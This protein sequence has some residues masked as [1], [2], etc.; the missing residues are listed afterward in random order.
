M[1]AAVQRTCSG[2]R[3][4]WLI[5]SVRR[6][7]KP[8]H[9]GLAR[10]DELLIGQAVPARTMTNQT[11][12][13]R[14]TMGAIAALLVATSTPLAAQN[15]GMPE[16]LPV[17]PAPAAPAP[18]SGAPAVP[19]AASPAIESPASKPASTPRTTALPNR[20]PVNEAP[21]ITTPIAPAPVE[22]AP[23]DAAPAAIVAAD[24]TETPE[25][26][27]RAR[28]SQSEGSAASAQP[29]AQ[30]AAVR[31]SSAGDAPDDNVAPAAE[32][33]AETLSAL[34]LENT[35]P[36]GVRPAVSEES[37][38]ASEDNSQ[39]DELLLAGLAG[40]AGLGLAGGGLILSRRRKRGSGRPEIQPV[41]GPNMP[42]GAAAPAGNRAPITMPA[43][44]A[45]PEPRRDA[46]ERLKGEQLAGAALIERIDYTQKPGYYTA[47]VD[48][49]PT[50]INPFLTRKYRMRRAHFLDRQL[51]K[52]GESRTFGSF[53]PE[54]RETDRAFE[55]A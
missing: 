36:L 50:A 22:D 12:P 2:N 26:P 20:A 30:T 27:A 10:P 37:V 54:A 28:P 42:N 21:I 25:A 4:F 51:A 24:D 15:S 33:E 46:I 17:V 40:L 5:F 53:A 43:V 32:S 49:G 31:R 1:A 3:A 13:H 23:G 34:P 44:S 41:A 19:P 48:Q 35:R 18:M 55:P 14:P 11:N 9:R 47:S 52:H 29:S 45:K 8:G 6:L 38:P 7:A 39:N 16:P